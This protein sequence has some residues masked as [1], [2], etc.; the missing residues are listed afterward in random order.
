M[1]R[2]HKLLLR[3]AFAI[4][5]QLCIGH[6]DAPVTRIPVDTWRR[7]VRLQRQFVLA[8][9][10]GWHAAANRVE[11]HLRCA[12]DMLANESS[13]VV[14][15]LD[16]RRQLAPLC[17]PQDIYGDLA[18]LDREFTAVSWNFGQKTLSVTTTRNRAARDALRRISKCSTSPWR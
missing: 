8:S 1:K 6:R 18:A 17:S 9:Q 10:R 4:H 3:L 7:C 2:P 12:M 11:R 14:R 15:E 16:D 5:G 13:R